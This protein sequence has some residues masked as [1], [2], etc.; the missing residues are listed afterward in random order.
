MHSVQNIWTTI[1]EGGWDK[2]FLV[3]IIGLDWTAISAIQYTNQSVLIIEIE[4]ELENTM[5]GKE[6]ESTE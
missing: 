1:V 5:D 3:T 4:E 2:D 6:K